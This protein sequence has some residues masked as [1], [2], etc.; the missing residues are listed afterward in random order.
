MFQGKNGRTF[1]AFTRNVLA[2]LGLV[3]LIAK[4]WH[5]R[6]LDALLVLVLDLKAGLSHRR[7]QQSPLRGS[8]E[9]KVFPLGLE[10]CLKPPV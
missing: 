9:L 4:R 2:F 1:R 10:R 5:R 8:L 6:E 3:G 7:K